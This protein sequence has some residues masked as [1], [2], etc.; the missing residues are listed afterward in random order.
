MTSSCVNSAGF[1]SD[2]RGQVARQVRDRDLHARRGAAAV[3]RVVHP[4]A[5][6]LVLAR[7]V[8]EV[9]LR[10]RRARLVGDV[11]EA[12]ARVPGLGLRLADAHAVDRLDDAEQSREDLVFREILAHGLVRERIA[13]VHELLAR[14]RDVPRL[15]LREVEAVARERQELGEVALG[16][17]L[18]ALGEVAQEREDLVGA[19]R[20]LGHERHGGVVGIAQELRRL[21]PQREHAL[22]QRRVVP[23]GLRAEVGCARGLRA[24][25]LGAQRAVVRV[26][27]HRQEARHAHG[28]LVA[29]AALG[30]RAS[31]ASVTTSS[32]RPARRLGS[33]T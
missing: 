9:E 20:H 1:A 23:L 28:E 33:S 18:R 4:R 10:D 22:D 7:V 11:E 8:V 31:R 2:R 15:E 12:H 25:Q 32:G 21:E 30:L 27:H 5:A 14:V 29:F 26:L 17:R 13:L 16:V 6:L 24:V 3:D 19:A